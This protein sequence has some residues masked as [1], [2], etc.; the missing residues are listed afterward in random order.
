MSASI[1]GS[2]ILRGACTPSGN[3]GGA[4]GDRL[5]QFVETSAPAGHDEE[6]RRRGLVMLDQ[7]ERHLDTSADAPDLLTPRIASLATYP[8]RLARRLFAVTI[9]WPHSCLQA[10]VKVVARIVST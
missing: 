5:R 2:G 9:A 6:A 1:T 8:T 3:K 7:L 4:V 10:A